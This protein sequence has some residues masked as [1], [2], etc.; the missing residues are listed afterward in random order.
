MKPVKVFVSPR[1]LDVVELIRTDI[2]LSTSWRRTYTWGQ[3]ICNVTLKTFELG[4]LLGGCYHTGVGW[5][6]ALPAVP[7]VPLVLRLEIIKLPGTTAHLSLAH[8][9]GQ[10]VLLRHRGVDLPQH[11]V[12]TARLDEDGEPVE[13]GLAGGCA[14]LPAGGADVPRAGHDLLG[15][16]G[17]EE[18]P[19]HLGSPRP[20]GLGTLLV[21]IR[22]PVILQLYIL[23]SDIQISLSVSNINNINVT[24]TELLT[25]KLSIQ[26]SV[27][28]VFGSL[29][30][31]RVL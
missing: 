29:A 9:D 20:P 16:G 22:V 19:G 15:G 3:L 28:C 7:P 10:N 17:L 27:M 13:A 1:H 26:G 21:K 5:G 8:H 25:V 4:F 31:Q 12:F 23:Q 11:E 2:R 14:D 18:L 30:Q 6:G 24:R